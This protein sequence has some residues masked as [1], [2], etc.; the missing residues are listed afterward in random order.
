[1][2]KNGSN[3]M[4]GKLKECRL[5]SASSPSSSC[6]HT[7]CRCCQ[8]TCHIRNPV[9]R[10]GACDGVVACIV[11]PADCVAWQGRRII[12]QVRASCCRRSVGGTTS[13]QR[14]QIDGAVGGGKGRQGRGPLSAGVVWVVLEGFGW[15]AVSGAAESGHS[16]LIPHQHSPMTQLGGRNDAAFACE[17]AMA[18]C[19]RAWNCASSSWRRLSLYRKGETSHESQNGPCQTGALHAQS[20]FRFE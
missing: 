11:V 7:P 1:M 10:A 2:E 6:I 17:P 4:A 19:T 14:G 13:T 15:V 20:V 12:A 18:R 16:P 9:L 5:S 8:K 3:G